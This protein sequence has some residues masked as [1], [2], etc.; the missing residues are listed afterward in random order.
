MGVWFES[1][2]SDRLWLEFSLGQAEQNDLN[3]GDK[4]SRSLILKKQFFYLFYSIVIHCTNFIIIIGNYVPVLPIA[5]NALS[6]YVAMA[7]TIM[8]QIIR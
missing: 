3:L 7:T 1:E 2:I 5:S 6:L 4:T 8:S